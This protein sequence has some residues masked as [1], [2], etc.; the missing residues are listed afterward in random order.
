MLE[1]EKMAFD[2]YTTMDEKWGTM[3]FNHIKQS[4][5]MHMDVLKNILKENNVKYNLLSQGKFN[6][7]NLQKLYNNLYSQG[8]KSEIEALKAGAKIEDVDIYDLIRLKK[9]TENPEIIKIY[10]FLE[11]GSRNHLRAFT[12][13][14]NKN[15]ETYRTEFISQKDYETILNNQQEPCGKDFGMQ[16]GKMKGQGKNC[17]DNSEKNCSGAEQT[18][19]QYGKQAEC[20]AEKTTCCGN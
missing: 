6:D 16:Q 3:Q 5:V 10:N 14:L 20:D 7:Q 2:I 4:E 9:Q 19:G 15:G 1:E 18:K 8:M 13:G 17:G 11:C 12:R